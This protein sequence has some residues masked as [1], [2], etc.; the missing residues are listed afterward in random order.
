MHVTLLFQKFTESD[1]AF[2]ILLIENNAE[3]YAKMHCEQKRVCRKETKS[4]SSKV[5]CSDTHLKVRIEE[6][7]IGS[8]VL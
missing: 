8:I 4:K 6:E 3:D 7:F 2:C 5:E 1:E